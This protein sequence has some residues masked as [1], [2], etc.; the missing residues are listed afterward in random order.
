[1]TQSD[2]IKKLGY[3]VGE[4]AHLKK[5]RHDNKEYRLWRN[6][7]RDI[8]GNIFGKGSGEYRRFAVKVRSFKHS[9]SEAEKQC[10]YLRALDEDTLDLKLIIERLSQGTAYLAYKESGAEYFWRRIKEDIDKAI[11]KAIE[12]GSPLDIG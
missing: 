11:E 6:E 8:L 5:L 1:M 4:I 9:A 10:A 3:L 2:S 7:V 12:R